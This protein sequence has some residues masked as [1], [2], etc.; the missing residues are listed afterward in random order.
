MIKC[1]E[2]LGRYYFKSYSEFYFML[3][4]AKECYRRGTYLDVSGMRIERDVSPEN[5][6]EYFKV[7]VNKGAIQGEGLN[8]DAKEYTSSLDLDTSCLSELE[9]EGKI[10]LECEDC[11]EWS[12]EFAANSY[13]KYNITL[14]NASKMGNSLI[15][16]SAYYLASVY[17]GYLPEKPLKITIDD[18]Q[19]VASTYIYINL[20]SCNKTMGL[21]KENIILNI[22]FTDFSVDL[23]YSI[24]CN[25]GIMAGRNKL[26]SI[27]EK[28]EFMKK[29]G[30]VEGSIVIL[31]ERKGM[32]E[33]N[34]IGRITG[35]TIVRVD[36]IEDDYVYVT[37]LY[38]VK[39]KE[40]LVDDYYD[41]PEDKRYMF[42]DLLDFNANTH[43]ESFSI[44]SLGVKNYFSSEES[45]FLDKIDD[46]ASVTKK[47]T[48]EGNTNY[49]EMSEIDAIYWLLC[50]F[51]IEFD[52]N[53]YKNMYNEGNDLLWDMYG[54]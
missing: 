7:L 3:A 10:F 37:C 45:M 11:L 39:T 25:N 46:T 14:L 33:S 15:H 49:V 4:V 18:R 48:V 41:I 28:K 30:I 24:F 52:R 32:N 38:L 35:S 1:N 5:M 43:P 19:K 13:S 12:Y 42:S 16:L 40:E 34:P 6:I 27:S 22:D 51:S 54:E 44:T 26:W 20:I 31:W 53:L 8:S 9:A 23:D 36:K 2:F 21:F 17:M 50:Q 47:V 29:E